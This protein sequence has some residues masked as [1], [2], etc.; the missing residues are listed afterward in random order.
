MD[1]LKEILNAYD[2]GL[3]NWTHAEHLIQENGDE[4]WGTFFS[5]IE[6]IRLYNDFKEIHIFI[7]G[8]VFPA[9]S[10]TGENCELH[11][12]HCDRKYLKSMLQA[13]TEKEFREVLTKIVQQGS[14]GALLSGGCDENGKVP[15]LKY[16]KVLR[17]FKS[18]KPFFFNAHVGLV[19]TEDALEL[20]K[21]GIDTVSLI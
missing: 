14:K 4:D 15:I 7:P 3:F 6:R 5:E 13:P 8:K 20:K 12:E 17:A 21:S 9:I 18:S 11:C 16:Q 10:V 19:N 1:S 2:Q